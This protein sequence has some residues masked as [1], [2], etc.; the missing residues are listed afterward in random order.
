MYLI[1]DILYK[2]KPFVQDELFKATLH[3]RS[4]FSRGAGKQSM[5][6]DPYFT[7]EHVVKTLEETMAS[8]NKEY[9]GMK[10]EIINEL[11]DRHKVIE[12]TSIL[13]AQ[14]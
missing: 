2:A 11:T 6:E 14:L 13:P 12:L 7:L 1:D 10:W 4:V 3:G 8:E 9:L 5:L